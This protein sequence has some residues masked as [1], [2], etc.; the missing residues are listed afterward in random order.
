MGQFEVLNRGDTRKAC[1]IDT[2]DGQVGR[3]IIV[4]IFVGGL[5][6]HRHLNNGA[7]SRSETR[8]GFRFLAWDRSARSIYEYHSARDIG[9]YAYFPAPL[10]DEMLCDMPVRK[11]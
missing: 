3:R 10:C 11:N 8:F 9:S 1:W 5:R 2:A 7:Y 6:R 4:R